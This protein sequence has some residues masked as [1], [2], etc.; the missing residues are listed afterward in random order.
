MTTTAEE[1]LARFISAAVR[2]DM[3]TVFGALLPEALMQVGTLNLA[4]VGQLRGFEVVERNTQGDDPAFTLR[5]DG[6]ETL[7]IRLIWRDVAG[8]W[9]VAGAA[10]AAPPGEHRAN[11]VEQMAGGVPLDL[12]WLDAKTEWG[13]RALPGPRGLTLEAVNVG[14][15]AEAPEIGE[16]ATQRP[17]GAAPN[18]DTPSMGVTIREKAEVW[19]PIAGAL[20]E[21]AIQRRWRPSTDIPWREAVELPMAREWAFCQ[22]CTALSERQAVSGDVPA[23]WERQISYDFHEVKLYLASQIFDAARHVEAFRKRALMNGGGLGRQSPGN[24]DRAIVDAESFSEMSLLSHVLV[25]GQTQLWLRLGAAR[26]PSAVERRLFTLALQD[27]GRVLAYGVSHLRFLLERRPDRAAELH[28]YLDKGEGMLASDDERDTTL[29]R[30]LV[31]IAAGG[32]SLG[33]GQLRVRT[34]KQRVVVEYLR[35]LESAGLGDRRGRLDQRL[36]AYLT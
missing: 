5:L 25:A 2:Q 3:A 8:T 21:E 18:A 14:S 13:V 23:G 24:V 6:D 33:S 16:H 36:G 26:A 32:G 27:V 35:R 4:A 30:A 20:Y 28:R 7:F 9:K 22:L 31:L 11:L 12:S 15:Y 29:D 17:R 19:S 10:R 1:A 34:L